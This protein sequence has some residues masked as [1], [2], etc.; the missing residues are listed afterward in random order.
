MPLLGAFVNGVWGKRLGKPAVRAMALLGVGLIV[1]RR[2]SSRSWML[3]YAVDH[4]NGPRSSPSTCASMWTAWEWMHTTGGHAGTNVPIDLKFSID[5]LSGVMMLVVTGVGFL[6][7]LYATSYM[8]EGPGLPA[9]LRVPEPVRLRDARPDPRGQPAGALRRLGGRRA[10]LVPPH[11]LLVRRAR[12]TRRPARRRSSRTA[13]ATSGCSV[14]DVPARAL[15][16]RA[17]LERHRR[18]ARRRS[19]RSSDAGARA[20]LAD[21]RRA[22]PGLPRRSSSRTTPLTISAATAV[23]LALLLGC[24]GKSAQIPLYVWLPDAMAG[25]TPVS[26]AHPRGHDGHGGRLPRLPP[27]VRLRALAV[28]DD[29][30]SPSSARPRRS[31]RR[32]SRS[33]RTTSRRCSPTPP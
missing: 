32:R 6:I 30:R 33:C 12:R 7:H 4:A 18:T 1:R 27:V 11:R 29:G 20:P 9:L 3:H 10:L 21:R 23:G 19:S 16:G 15:H 26:R 17:R 13:S 28:H 14:G 31:S 2:A 22:V 5:A 25:P 8:A 24:T